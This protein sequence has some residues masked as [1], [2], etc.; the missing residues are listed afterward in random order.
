MYI[1]FHFNVKF[2]FKINKL[3]IYIIIHIIIKIF[4]KKIY[5]CLDREEYIILIERVM[6]FYFIQLLQRK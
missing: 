1:N 6:F 3:K 4:I 5:V 2:L